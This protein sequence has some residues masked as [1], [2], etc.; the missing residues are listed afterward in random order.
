M[1]KLR[2]FNLFGE[3]VYF[4]SIAASDGDRQVKYRT[5]FDVD[6]DWAVFWHYVECYITEAARV[7]GDVRVMMQDVTLSELEEFCDL[8]ST[9]RRYFNEPP[10]FR[11]ASKKVESSFSFTDMLVFSFYGIC[12]VVSSFLLFWVYLADWLSA[13]VFLFEFVFV[14]VCSTTWVNDCRG[15]YVVIFV[16]LCLLLSWPCIC[17][18]VFVFSIGFFLWSVVGL[19]ACVW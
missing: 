18:V 8:P 3:K 1:V 16:F 12:G 4:G 10:Q 2:C 9:H 5:T 7:D 6:Y 19:L 11:T 14:F 15:V 13:F 17:G